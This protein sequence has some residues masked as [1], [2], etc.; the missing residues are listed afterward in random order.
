MTAFVL[1]GLASGALFY[2]AAPGAAPRPQ[3][4][5]RSGIIQC[6]V[7]EIATRAEYESAILAS[8]G[9]KLTVVSFGMTWC[10]PCTR[11]AEDYICL[12]DEF[13]DSFFYKVTASRQ[14]FC[15]PMNAAWIDAADL[16]PCTHRHMATRIRR[17]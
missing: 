4:I 11:I 10:K 12:S 2:R 8:A 6:V 3:L 7:N 15:T 14:L 13:P 9:H 5:S 1:G 16:P 17:P